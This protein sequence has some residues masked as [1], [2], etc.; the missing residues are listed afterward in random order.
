ME[1]VISLP[2]RERCSNCS[3]V[4]SNTPD[5]I[6]LFTKICMIDKN[7]KL[8]ITSNVDSSGSALQLSS[9]LFKTLYIRQT[10]ENPICNG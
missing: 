7:N 8:K 5:F 9:V 1:N 4:F 10:L 2:S 6:G 3:T